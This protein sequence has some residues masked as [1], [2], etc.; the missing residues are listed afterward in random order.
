MPAPTS[1]VAYVMPR[2]FNLF[3][4]SALISNYFSSMA[5]HALPFRLG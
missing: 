4:V 2:A 1:F 5:L 3:P